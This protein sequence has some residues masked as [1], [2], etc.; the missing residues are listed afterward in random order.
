MATSV[1]N[2]GIDNQLVTLV[3]CV[4]WCRD[5]CTY[6]QQRGRGGR[7][8]TQKATFLQLGSIQ[9]YVSLMFQM[10]RLPANDEDDK[11]PSSEL[12]GLNSAVSPVREN[13]VSRRKKKSY[14]SKLA[15]HQKRLNTMRSRRELLEVVAFE[16]LD[17]GCKHACAEWFL[18]T[19][20][21]DPPPREWVH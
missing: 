17:H 2:V 9:S 7:N 6:F 13:V 19:G 15:S 5:L 14:S 20:K 3:A 18:S 11:R 21:A 12:D 1:A 4:G 16:V 8:P 10:Y